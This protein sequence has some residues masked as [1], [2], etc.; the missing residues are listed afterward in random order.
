MAF[1]YQRAIPVGTLQIIL[2]ITWRFELRGSMKMVQYRCS[3][4]TPLSLGH[5]TSDHK[6][7][8]NG[9]GGRGG[10]ESLYQTQPAKRKFIISIN[11][12][13]FNFSSW[14]SKITN[15]Y[16]RK[17]PKACGGYSQPRLWDWKRVRNGFAWDWICAVYFLVDCASLDVLVSLC[18]FKRIVSFPVLIFL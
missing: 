16:K 3:S 12:R 4:V 8:D 13:N 18:S 5:S 15:S 6:V 9:G 2:S 11:F 7:D 17:K 10:G 1:S 14:F